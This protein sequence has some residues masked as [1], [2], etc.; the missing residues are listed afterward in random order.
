MPQHIVDS[1]LQA[2]PG[3]TLVAAS[4][5]REDGEDVYEVEVMVDGVEFEVEVAADGTILEIEEE[6]AEDGD[7]EDGNGE[8]DAEDEDAEDED[9]DKIKR[10]S[11][12]SGVEKMKREVKDIGTMYALVSLFVCIAMPLAA[13]L[14]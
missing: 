7:A 4:M 14:A 6:N 11:Y 8:D 1:V 5:E 9:A 2:F 3:A 12:Q 13:A 10:C